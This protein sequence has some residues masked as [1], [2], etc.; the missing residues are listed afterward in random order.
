MSWRSDQNAT[1]MTELKNFAKPT[2]HTATLSILSSFWFPRASLTRAQMLP[3]SPRYLSN[4]I[5]SLVQDTGV[6]FPSSIFTS[7]LLCMVAGHK[8]II[9]RTREEDVG[10]VKALVVRVECTLYFL[11]CVFEI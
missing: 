3:G 9:L 4:L 5:H 6:A 8:H 11:R 2:Y 1:E 10:E 7:L